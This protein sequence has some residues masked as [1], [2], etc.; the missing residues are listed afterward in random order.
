V[1]IA[2]CR[3]EP[4]L[5]TA[6]KGDSLRIENTTDKPFL[7]SFGRSPF[8][9]ALLAGQERTVAVN[10]GGEIAWAG[11]DGKVEKAPI[12]DLVS[13]SWSREAASPFD[14]NPRNVALR[15]RGGDRILGTLLPGEQ[16]AIGIRSPLLGGMGFLVDDVQEVRFLDAWAR[17]GEKPVFGDEE[18]TRDV[19][20]YDNLDRLTGTFLQVT[21]RAVLVHGRTGDR[22]PV[23]FEKLLAIRFADLE[24]PEPAEG[25][26]MVL[27]LTDGSRITARSVTADGSRLRAETLRGEEIEVELTDLLALHQK[28]GRF[29][30]L[31]DLEPAEEEIVPWLGEVYAWDRP[32]YDRSLLDRPL[33]SGGETYLKGIG[34]ISGTSITWRLDGTWRRF[35]SRVALDDS[36]GE[37]GDVEFE[38][39]VD[40]KR[41]YRSP[42]VRPGGRPVRIPGIDLEG[43]ESITLRVTYA[44]DFVMDF[45]NWIEPMLI[46]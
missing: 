1:K 10:E 2:D 44:D 20:V 29:V 24:P 31:S 3:L 38:V 17:P 34:V 45:A 26:V 46:R 42:V 30:Y 41:R 35:A 13:V 11:P 25:T 14:E 36:A 19:F 8:T 12:E 22:Y 23:Q 39:L 32:R 4:R 16:D 9:Q 33:R 40:G 6:T 18:R 7:P 21:P 27:R 43:A 37:E 15:L 5:V 28:G